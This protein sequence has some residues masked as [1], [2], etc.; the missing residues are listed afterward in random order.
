MLWLVAE[1]LSYVVL[2]FEEEEIMCKKLIFLV[3]LVAILGLVG[4]AHGASKPVYWDAGGTD[5]LWDTIANWK[6]YDTTLY[7]DNWVP[8]GTKN[9]P[10]QL[11]ALS[12]VGTGGAGTATT[13][14]I[15]SSVTAI[16][17]TTNIGTCFGDSPAGA[18]TDGAV[19]PATLNMTGGTLSTAKFHVGQLSLAAWAARDMS[20]FNMS[21][22]TITFNTLDATAPANLVVGRISPGTMTM[23]AGVVNVAKKVQI[24]WRR[25]NNDIADS[26]GSVL[27]LWG[28]TIN[29]GTTVGEAGLTI[30][31]VGGSLLDIRNYAVMKLL[32]V[33][34]VWTVGS[35]IKSGLIT[36]DGLGAG[37][38]T[39][40]DGTDTIVTPEPATMM[41]LGLGGLFLVRRKR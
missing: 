29:V 11:G 21:G 26:D 9:G 22:G 27:N 2:V 8:D 40:F 1:V 24:A 41:L 23:T 14:L 13:A 33:D 18:V 38:V 15:D 7:A 17:H 3:S 28:G 16:S 30:G 31:D 39:Y 25:T 37:V 19:G 4:N 6:S 32:G 5:N 10:G 34:T 35:L 36:G 12:P 20:Y